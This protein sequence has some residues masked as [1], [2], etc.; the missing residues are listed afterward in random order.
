VPKLLSVTHVSQFVCNELQATQ[1]PKS[2]AGTRAEEPQ[3]K[4]WAEE[5]LELHLAQLLII[6]E[7]FLHAPELR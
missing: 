3:S 1:E 5:L 4:H 6:W 7:Q 2:A